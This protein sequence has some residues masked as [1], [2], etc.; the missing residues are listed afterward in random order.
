MKAIKLEHCSMGASTP[1]VVH[2]TEAVVEYM[3]ETTGWSVGN[4]TEVKKTK[5][6]V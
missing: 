5:E 4:G 3:A 6:E 2:S 1:R